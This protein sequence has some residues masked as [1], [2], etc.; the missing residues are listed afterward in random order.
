MIEFPIR[1]LM[2]E[3]ACY[4]YLLEV[5]HPEGLHCPQGH[6]LPDDQAPHDK[7][8]APIVDYRCRTC[9]AVFNIFTNTIWSKSRYSCAIIVLIL[10]GIAQGVPTAHLAKELG[11]DR[12][13]LLERRHEIQRLIEQRFPPSDT[14]GQR[15]WGR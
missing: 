15:S 5:L 1:S 8:R 2:D 7:R 3:Q 6:V 9:G 4:N 11:V 14:A 13:H 12:T 10:R